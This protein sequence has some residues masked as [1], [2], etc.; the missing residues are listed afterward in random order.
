VL[1]IHSGGD[2]TKIV[3]VLLDS[4]GFVAPYKDLATV[5]VSRRQHISAGTIIGTTGAR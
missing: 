3:D 5:N 2:G 4:G 1:G